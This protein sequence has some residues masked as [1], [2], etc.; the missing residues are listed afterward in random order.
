M[1][2]SFF[3]CCRR[4]RLILA[5]LLCA[6]PSSLSGQAF[7]VRITPRFGL[8]DPARALYDTSVRSADD[9]TISSSA[10]LAPRRS[11]GLAI[12]LGSAARGVVLRLSV[13]HALSMRSHLR[14]LRSDP[15]GATIPTG[16]LN[17]DTIPASL[18]EFG[19]ELVLPLRLE[20]GPVS[21]YVVAGVG[22][23]HFGFELPN[24]EFGV[25]EGWALPVSATSGTVRLGGG[26]DLDVRGQ[27]MV[28]SIVDG[29]SRYWGATQHHIMA[30]VGLSFGLRSSR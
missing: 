28:L 10:G 21:P 14:F 15:P 2:A 7:D 5:G 23:R 4:P 3:S 16:S 9:R 1:R 17:R 25:P 11:L 12:D 6:L 8:I 22:A 18:T 20:L 26:V 19:L 29:V 24:Y 30:S 27:R 13:D